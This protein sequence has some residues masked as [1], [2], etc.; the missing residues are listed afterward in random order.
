MSSIISP[1]LRSTNDSVEPELFCMSER[2]SRF[3]H[4]W[5][6]HNFEV[7]SRTR[8]SRVSQKYFHSSM[9]A[10]P[11]IDCLPGC[12]HFIKKV[13]LLSPLVRDY[14]SHTPCTVIEFPSTI[15]SVFCNQFKSIFSCASA[16]RLPTLLINPT[17]CLMIRFSSTISPPATLFHQIGTRSMFKYYFITL[18][19]CLP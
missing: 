2:E 9:Q 5:G 15:F 16:F 19:V 1:N 13:G 12:F 10:L 14:I 8:R 7:S 17:L 3:Q 4:S 18:T 6:K 11:L